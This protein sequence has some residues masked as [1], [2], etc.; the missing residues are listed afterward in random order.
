[1]SGFNWS[2]LPRKIVSCWPGW[3][4]IVPSRSRW[5][6]E[7]KECTTLQWCPPWTCFSLLQSPHTWNTLRSESFKQRRPRSDT[8]SAL[9]L[10]AKFEGSWELLSKYWAGFLNASVP[11]IAKGSTN[12]E[13]YHTLSVAVDEFFHG[14]VSSRQEGQLLLEV[15]PADMRCSGHLTTLS[16]LTGCASSVFKF[17]RTSRPDSEKRGIDSIRTVWP[18]GPAMHTVHD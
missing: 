3:Y 15:C 16:K 11:W 13:R 17:R 8:L 7:N 4:S 14:C 18:S 9:H 2:E 1:M 12:V 10:L 5:R 6:Q